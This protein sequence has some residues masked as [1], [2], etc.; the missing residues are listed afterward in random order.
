MLTWAKANGVR[1][2]G[3][4]TS[5]DTSSKS[6]PAAEATASAR[7]ELGPHQLAA[8]A[9]SARESE[10]SRVREADLMFC[11]GP[12]RDDNSFNNDKEVHVFLGKQRVATGR[13]PQQ[14]G[15]PSEEELRGVATSSI[16][17]D[18]V[19][20]T[21]DDVRSAA[22]S[23]TFGSAEQSLAFLQERQTS[24]SQVD[25]DIESLQSV[26]AWHVGVLTSSVFGLSSLA[27]GDNLK[28][29]RTDHAGLYTTDVSRA[30]S[31]MSDVD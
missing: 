27:R 4:L 1:S 16:R 10:V 6:V 7:E 3:D 12:Y 5:R 21:P 20:D 23:A 17:F 26:R 25:G 31:Q 15:G 28:D 30:R 14:G 19:Q 22:R 8:S 9:P 13:F 18:Q 29:T 24:I 11:S 2:P